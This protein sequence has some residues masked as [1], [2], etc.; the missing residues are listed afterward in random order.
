MAIGRA[1]LLQV[2]EHLRCKEKFACLQ[3]SY[4]PGPGC[5]EAFY[6]ALGFRQTGR[7][8]G[9]EIVLELPLRQ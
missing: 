4:K 8:D 5:A 2:I 3:L 1:A 7:M 6:T 9:D